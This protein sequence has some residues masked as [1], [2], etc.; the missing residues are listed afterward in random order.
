MYF[1]SSA[2]RPQAGDRIWCNPR[3]QFSQTPYQTRLSAGFIGKR[4]RWHG[5]KGLFRDC[6]NRALPASGKG[7]QDS[8]LKRVGSMSERGDFATVTP[9]TSWAL[10]VDCIQEQKN[11]GWLFASPITDS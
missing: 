5:R 6:E 7:F 11:L 8:I 9:P 2:R 1:Q 4:Q 10:Q 3:V